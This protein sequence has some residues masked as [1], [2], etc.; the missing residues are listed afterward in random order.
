LTCEIFTTFYF[1]KVTVYTKETSAS[2]AF[3]SSVQVFRVVKTHSF[4]VLQSLQIRSKNL[5]LC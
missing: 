1:I 3:L 4:D 2:E 5:R